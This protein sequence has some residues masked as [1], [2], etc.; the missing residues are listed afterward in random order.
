MRG[1]ASAEVIANRDVAPE[2]TGSAGR[3]A[4]VSSASSSTQIA[5]GAK[6]LGPRL[7]EL[8]IALAFGV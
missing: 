7:I 3:H 2:I 6:L 8:G 1:R 5:E 4:A